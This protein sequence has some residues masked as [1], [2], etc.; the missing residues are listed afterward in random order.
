MCVAHIFLMVSSGLETVSYIIKNEVTCFL[1]AQAHMKTSISKRY[2]MT[3]VTRPARTK[4]HFKGRHF[5][6]LV[7]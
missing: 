5:V 2:E 3:S 6:L 4:T 7:L 1:I